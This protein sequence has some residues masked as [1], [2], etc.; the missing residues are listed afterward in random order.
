MYPVSRYKMVCFLISKYEKP[1]ESAKCLIDNWKPIDK[2]N[3]SYYKYIYMYSGI[4]EIN[5]KLKILLCIS[6]NI[7]I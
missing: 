7:I 3:C 4:N 2:S 6:Q 5:I 1:N